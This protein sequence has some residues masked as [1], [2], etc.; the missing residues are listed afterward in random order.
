[1]DEVYYCLNAYLD[2]FR[3]FIEELRSTV[4]ER[5]IED[6]KAL[7]EMLDVFKSHLQVA[8]LQDVLQI[9]TIEIFISSINKPYYIDKASNTIDN[10]E[11]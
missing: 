8:S 1:M 4:N 3:G 10:I 7:A 9:D 2:G 5:P 6:P 11:L